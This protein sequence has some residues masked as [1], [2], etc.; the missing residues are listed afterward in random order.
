MADEMK[1]KE[2]CGILQDPAERTICE[3][4]SKDCSTLE[5]ERASACLGLVEVC[6]D[7][8]KK[9][10]KS[11]RLLDWTLPTLESCLRNCAWQS[12]KIKKSKSDRPDYDTYCASAG[13][14]EGIEGKL[15]RD[16]IGKCLEGEGPYSLPLGGKD[17]FLRLD[18]RNECLF[19][20]P[21]VAA[22]LAQKATAQKK[23][24]RTTKADKNFTADGRTSFAMSFGDAGRLRLTVTEEKKSQNIPLRFLYKDSYRGLNITLTYTLKKTSDQ[25]YKMEY[26]IADER[27]NTIGEKRTVEFSASGNLIDQKLGFGVVLNREG[28]FRQIKWIGIVGL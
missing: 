12:K 27:G 3:T 6:L 2:R 26:E 7:H 19:M 1:V 17:A 23:A 8:Y 21:L 13:P 9:G 5:E 25:R 15:C 18:T 10:A 4:V 14:A 24:D 22:G 16:L 20:A 28:D 11:Y